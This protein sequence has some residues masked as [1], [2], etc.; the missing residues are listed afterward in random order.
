MDICYFAPLVL[1]GKPVYTVI[2]IIISGIDPFE[3]FIEFLVYV[4]GDRFKRKSTN[5]LACLCCF[6]QV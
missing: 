4:A 5:S 1:E 3:R 2:P 6:Q